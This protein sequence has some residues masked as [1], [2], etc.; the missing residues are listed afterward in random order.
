VT[1][2]AALLPPQFEEFRI[3]VQ[4]L[5]EAHSF[6]LSATEKKKKKKVEV[7]FVWREKDDKG[8][9]D[10]RRLEPDWN[11]ENWRLDDAGGRNSE[12]LLIKVYF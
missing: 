5:K 10:Q 11:Q 12:A 2:E 8:N 9:D 4:P 6:V 3:W 7:A 1:I